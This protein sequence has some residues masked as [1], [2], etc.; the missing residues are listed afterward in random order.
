MFSITTIASSMTNPVEIVSAMSDRLSSEYP[1]RYIAAKVP[2][3]E[4]GT[5]MPGMIVAR[6]SRR[7]TKTTTMTSRIEMSSVRST[8]WSDARMVV[9]WS[10]TSVTWWLAGIAARIAGR[11]AL[12]RSTVSMMFEPGCLK[13]ITMTDG[14]PFT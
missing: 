7:K 1:S 14:S 8:S 12:M 10:R 13:T 4:T 11:A 2:T 5:A 6:Q 9:V 3:S